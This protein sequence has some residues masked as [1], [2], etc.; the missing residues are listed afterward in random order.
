RRGH[1]EAPGGHHPVDDPA[2]A[3]RLSAAERAPQ[4]AHRRRLGHH[5]AGDQPAAEAVP[6]HE[7]DD[8]AGPGAREEGLAGAPSARPD[9]APRRLSMIDHVSISV[10]DFAKALAFYDAVLAPLGYQRL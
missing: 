3:P 1:A 7:P 9:G 10:A 8:E 5:R 4:A 6:G 2:R